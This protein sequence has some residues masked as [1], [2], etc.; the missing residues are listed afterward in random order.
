MKSMP[1][2]TDSGIWKLFRSGSSSPKI[3][4]NSGLVLFV[5]DTTVTDDES[6]DSEEQ[7]VEGFPLRR[8]HAVEDAQKQSPALP[9]LGWS[10]VRRKIFNE[11]R[12][13]LDADS[14]LFR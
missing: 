9:Q 8:R 6:E 2:S 5:D 1:V 3:T 11:D 14:E 7:D 13:V 4:S 12:E 10:L